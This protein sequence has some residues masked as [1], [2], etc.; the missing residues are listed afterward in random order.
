LAESTFKQQ[1]PAIYNHLLEHKKA[2][3]ERNK[4]ET[5]IRYEWYAMQRWGANYWE[6]FFRQKIVWKR[7]GSILRFCFDDEGVFVLDSTCFAVGEDLK[8]ILAILNSRMGHY[9]LKD[10][11]K[12]G[13][14][15]LLISVQAIEPLLIPVAKNDKKQQI[16]EMANE[17][18]KRM[19]NKDIDEKLN[20]IIYELYDLER[21]EIN[22][23]E[24]LSDI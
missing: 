4:A 19:P 12:T 1:Y 21:D 8:Y 11:P 23:L 18:L 3:L 2:L 14:G 10:A 9:L 5:G 22:Y 15:D 6:D 20:A 17:L 24:L 16:T 7:V 13:T